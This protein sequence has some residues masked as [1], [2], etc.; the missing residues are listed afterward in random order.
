MK[1]VDNSVQL[2]K[3]L[4]REAATD[5]QHRMWVLGNG[6]I[7]I[8]PIK[9]Q[10]VDFEQQLCWVT[11]TLDDQFEDEHCLVPNVRVKVYFENSSLFIFSKVKSF[12]KESNL[13]KFFFPEVGFFKERRLEGRYL[14]EDLAN[15]DFAKAEPWKTLSSRDLRPIKK[16]F[17]ISAGGLSFLL[18]KGE[19]LPINQ[20]DKLSNIILKIGGK[21]LKI[22]LEITSILKISPF[23]FEAIP[24]GNR[25][26]CCRI[27]FSKESDKPKW[28]SFLTTL[29]S[30]VNEVE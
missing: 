8:I 17:D 12:K 14:V 9:L 5:E 29:F 28:S 10:K 18:A 30:K 27:L 6:R 16:V 25:K 2:L 4:Q 26:V 24:Y 19:V 1:E 20:G 15:L 11:T 21:N 22:S 7:Q 13:L 3:M 23:V